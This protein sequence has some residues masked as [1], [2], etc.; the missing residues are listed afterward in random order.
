MSPVLGVSLEAM[1]FQSCMVVS[2]KHVALRGKQ[3][4][5]KQLSDYPYLDWDIARQSSILDLMDC[6]CS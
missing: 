4:N 6:C 5:N 2:Q 3:T 1:V